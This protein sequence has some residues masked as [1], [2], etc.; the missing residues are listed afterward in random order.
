MPEPTRDLSRA[1]SRID[2]RWDGAR[3]E[4]T[5]SA[6]RGRRRRRRLAGTFAAVS[7]M[8]L[9]V[10][11]AVWQL[12]QPE[13][14]RKATTVV[15]AAPQQLEL[16]D[17]SQVALHDA[18]SRVLVRRDLGEVVELELAAGKARFEV[19]HRKQRSFE[20]QCG[21][22]R[23]RVLGTVFELER[24]GAR[25][26]VEVLRGRVAVSYPGGESELAAGEAAWFP[27]HEVA[28]APTAAEPPARASKRPAARSST[29][30][31]ERAEQGDFEHAYE[32]LERTK[33][34]VADDVEE[35]LLAADS[36]RLSGHP[37]AALPYLQRVIARHAKDSRAGLAAFTLGGVFM[38]QLGRPREAEAAYARARELSLNAS[39]SEDALARQ[40]E[41]AH[42]AGDPA[43]ARA[44]AEEYLARYPRGRRVHAVQRFGGL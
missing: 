35:L 26:R 22:V 11:G 20:V 40:V 33:Q 34:P 17:G 1:L 23:V 13:V 16:A 3:T 37:E 39:L 18:Q 12:S 9:A 21:D 2:E 5:L 19:V 6:L 41:A 29:G 38:Q 8:L 42:R 25:T 30:W 32:L 10:A 44:L 7:C 14:A 15:A 31:R 4:R 27:R 24:D 43:R 36:A 28:P